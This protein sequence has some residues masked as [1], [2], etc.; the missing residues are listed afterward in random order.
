VDAFLLYEV[1]KGRL[2]D[3][4]FNDRRVRVCI[5][6]VSLYTL[7]ERKEQS[8]KVRSKRPKKA[9][10]VFYDGFF[11]SEADARGRSSVLFPE[12][13][14][15]D[16]Y[17]YGINIRRNPYGKKPVPPRAVL[18][19]PEGRWTSA[20]LGD[21]PSTRTPAS[22]KFQPVLPWDGLERPD[23]PPG[24]QSYSERLAP[25]LYAR[26]PFS[27]SFITGKPPRRDWIW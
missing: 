3:M 9:R 16:P 25:I 5:S 8:E 1:I 7:V 11:H 19:P 15:D 22:K 4:G 18:D 14:G 21:G 10:P 17:S 2:R 26:Q 27:L 13:P 6:C 20:S 23:V 24:R 12:H